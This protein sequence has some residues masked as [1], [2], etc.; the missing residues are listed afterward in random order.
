MNTIESRIKGNTKVICILG[1]PVGHS[2]SPQIHNHIFNK[3]DLNYV[4]IP[5][6]VPA[7]SLHT[8]MYAI[9]NFGFTGANVTIPHKEQVLPYCDSISELSKNIGAVNTL[10][11]KDS[12][13]C[14]TSTDYEGFKRAIAK[15]NFNFSGSKVV[16]LGNGGTARTLAI[17][18]ILDKWDSLLTIAGRNGF[19]VRQLADSIYKSTGQSVLSC[20]FSDKLFGE[21]MQECTLLINTTSAGMHPSIND[22]PIDASYFRPEMTVFD[23]IYNPSKTRFLAEAQKAGCHIQNGL[24]MLLY[25]ALASSKIWTGVDVPEDII[26]LTELAKSVGG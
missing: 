7:T 13:L 6:A 23:V 5:V 8:A 14:G 15:M 25:Q 18:L 20:S 2:L 12:R 21:V 10:Y 9:K 1:N 19:K 16:I 3:L 11:V 4:Y 24:P 22:T 26:P 17:A